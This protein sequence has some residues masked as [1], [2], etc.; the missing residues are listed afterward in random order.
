MSAT[1]LKL[2]IHAPTQASLVRARRYLSNVL[3]ARPGLEVCIVVNGDGVDAVLDAPDE[4]PDAKTLIC[5]TTLKRT[6]RTAPA[7]LTVMS[8][9][10]VVS[11]GL[12]QLEGWQYIRA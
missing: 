5:P 6:G 8:E 1:E 12:M 9:P 7:P 11:L 10:G 3:Q 4:L 2:V